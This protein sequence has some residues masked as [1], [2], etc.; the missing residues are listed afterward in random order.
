[1]TQHLY[2]DKPFSSSDELQSISSIRI[3][4]IRIEEI[5]KSMEGETIRL[6]AR[7][8]RVVKKGKLCFVRLRR[9]SHSIQACFLAKN[10]Q[11]REMVKYIG[12][13][14][15]ES[16]VEVVGIIV[17]RKSKSNET[18]SELELEMKEI[19]CLSRAQKLDYELDEL[20]DMRQ[21]RS[22]HTKRYVSLRH[23]FMHHI[24]KLQSLIGRKFCEYMY[25]KDFTEIHTP[26]IVKNQSDNNI[27]SFTF[28]YFGNS[29]EL[30][31]SSHLHQ[32]LAI[33][34]GLD[35]VFEI[36]CAFEKHHGC[37]H[38]HLNEKT[39][40]NFGMTIASHYHEVISVVKELLNY[41][42]DEISEYEGL[43]V[44]AKHNSRGLEKLKKTEIL[45]LTFKEA[46][47]LLIANCSENEFGGFMALREVASYFKDYTDILIIQNSAHEEVGCFEMPSSTG[48]GF[49]NFIIL[50]RGIVVGR[51]CQ[52]IHDEE[53]LK[54]QVRCH[55]PDLVSA[56]KYGAQP[57]GGCSIDLELFL[58]QFLQLSNVR[59]TS[60]FP[61]APTI[62]ENEQLL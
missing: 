4:D 30:T 55:A 42:I 7:A 37:T 53:L 43:E 11:E 32:Q 23:S 60:L 46:D 61:R 12:G 5:N 25:S 6:I 20:E 28:D 56:L 40:L 38:V 58:M 16:I 18:V 8:S 31:T 19:Y 50:I 24:F 14:P 33:H 2:G 13:I 35:R 22:L 45:E 57:C 1:M 47:A 54:H 41:I 59:F 34:G 44:I 27:S 9:N 21:S 3:N 15:H 62:Y 51:G 10:D 48:K 39:T 17:M 26:H 52:Y 49:N 29:V 36:S